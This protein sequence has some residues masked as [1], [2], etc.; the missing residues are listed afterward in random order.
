MSHPFHVYGAA[1]GLVSALRS[2]LGE[3]TKADRSLA[4]QLRRAASSVVLNIAEGNQ[5]TGKDRLHFF[6]IAA[7]SA[8]EVRAA[9]EVA[10]AWGMIGAAPVAEAELDRVL[11]M[12][13]RLTH[14]RG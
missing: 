13:W 5:R 2:V 12:L 14:R 3:L 8:A 6:R 10:R 9:L 11:A 7:G 1:L 4:D